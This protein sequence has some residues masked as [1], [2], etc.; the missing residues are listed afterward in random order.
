MTD[1]TLVPGGCRPVD[2]RARLSRR[3]HDLMQHFYY[4]IRRV[5]SIYHTVLK[6]PGREG[7][8]P[9]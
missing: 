9:L 6:L 8:N 1:R 2:S 4:Q 3:I 7:C 5:P